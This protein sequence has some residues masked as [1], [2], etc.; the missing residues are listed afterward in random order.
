[1]NETIE[2]ENQSIKDYI[3]EI[4]EKLIEFFRKFPFKGSEEAKDIVAAICMMMKYL[5]I[6]MHIKHQ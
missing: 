6:M 2:E 4:L 3:Y 1:M 5:M